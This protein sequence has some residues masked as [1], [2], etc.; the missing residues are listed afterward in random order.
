LFSATISACAASVALIVTDRA[1]VQTIGRMSRSSSRNLTYSHTAT[2]TDCRFMVSTSAI[3][4]NTWITTRLPTPE[5]R[6]AEL[7][8]LHWTVCPQS[9]S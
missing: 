7:A 8:S 4:V 6:K 5:G 3:H 9:Q 1:G 2:R